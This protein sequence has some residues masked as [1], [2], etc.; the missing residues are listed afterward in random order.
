MLKLFLFLLL[1]C[2]LYADVSVTRT[3]TIF[4]A[5]Y[6]DD[7]LVTLKQKVLEKAKLKASKEIYGEFMA[8]ESDME[9]GHIVDDVVRL[10]SGGVV[11]IKGEP[12]FKADEKSVS[13]TINAY[14]TDVDLG[15]N[16]STMPLRVKKKK[17]RTKKGFTGL[18]YGFVMDKNNNSSSVE[19]S[20][21]D[22]SQAVINYKSQE[23]AGDLIVKEKKSRK[24]TFKEILTFG[25]DRCKNNLT[26]IIQKVTPKSLEFTQ[27]NG[28][29]ILFR[30]RLY[31][32][33]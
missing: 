8:T 4:K 24:V 14:A 1:A 13:V 32:V 18:W 16:Y 15:K 31:L 17:K 30:G 19:I 28:D 10:V 33:K 5:D 25:K 23:C 7:S 26:I 29:G 6:P 27:K 3:A 21:S 20:I 2:G 11:H 12:R 9:D 22:F